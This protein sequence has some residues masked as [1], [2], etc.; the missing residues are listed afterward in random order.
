MSELL[1]NPLALAIIA[2]LLGLLIGSFINVV[3]ARLPVMLEREW[4]AEARYVLQGEEPAE[5]TGAERFDLIR[6]RSRCPHCQRSIRAIENIPLLSFLFL[7][8]RCPGCGSR[9]SWQYP[10]VELLTGLLFAATLWHFGASVEAG[11]AL[12]LT[13]GLIA[14][15]GIDAR[16]TLLPDQ[17]TLPLLWLGLLVNSFGVFTD[18][19]SAVFGAMAG[20]LLLWLVF[21]GFRL[22]TGKEGMGYG[23]FKLLAALGAW[24]GWQAI[25]V[26]LLLASLVGAVVGI[27]LIVLRGRD[28]N[29]PIPFG[30]YLAAAGWLT[31]I[32]GD[33][34][35]RIYFPHGL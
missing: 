27:A 31:L 15:G 19:Q 2:G 8:G 34:L 26:I 5:D 22:L 3:I 24:L 25:P 17:L 20:Y 7:R 29:I 23:D 1:A 32:T 21:H 13:G 9:I 16:T 14:A 11:L 33:A 18:L 30:P 6:P 28:R 10:A 12:V 35:L 4:Q